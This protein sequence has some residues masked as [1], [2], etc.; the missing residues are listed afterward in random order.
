MS[1]LREFFI[2]FK[3]DA[4]RVQGE[5]EGADKA[6]EKLATDID[7]AGKAMPAGQIAA[8]N[9]AL[10]DAGRQARE[11]D[12]ELHD[13]GRSAD[14]IDDGVRRAN[15][16]LREANKN[17]AALGASFG[18]AIGRL[19]ATAGAYFGGRELITYADEYKNLQSQ[20]KLT[21]KTTEEFANASTGVFRIAQNTRQS[22]E[23]TTSLYASLQR[24]T[25]SL[26]YSQNRLLGVTETINQAITISG[27]S[28]AAA[29]AALVQLGQGFASG[30]LRGEELNSVL[31]Q[32]PR[33]AKAIADGMGVT[34]GQLRQLGQD[35]KITADTVFKALEGQSAAIK[36]EFGQM[37]LTVGSSMIVLRNA[38]VRFV[39]E[40][41]AATGATDKL[42]KGISSLADGMG[43]LFRWL[44]DNRFLIQGFAIGAAAA[45]TLVSAVLWGSLVPGLVTAAAAALV[46]Y[47]PF[48]ALGAA[49]TALAA[50]IALA[51]ED[52]QFFLKGQPSLLGELVKKYEW[53]ART[54]RFI[55]DAIN[56]LGETAETIWSA[57][58]V[59][60]S[61]AADIFQ[62]IA[63]VAGAAFDGV[64][65]VAG[66]IL[67]LLW[68]GMQ[69]LFRIS[70]T[71][72][73]GILAAATEVFQALAPVVMPVLQ[74]IG[75]LVQWVGDIFAAVAKAIWGEWGAMFDR[76]VDRLNFVIG[77]IRS[78]M[79]L[80]E[81]ARVGFEGMVDRATGGRGG[82]AAVAAGQ[83]QMRAAAANPLASQTAASVATRG[84]TS[85]R[86]TTVN[87]GKVEVQTQATDANGIAKSV[88]PALQ[89]EMRRTAQ[90]FDDGIA[91]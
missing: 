72:W 13:A 80:A 87:V 54:V 57:L 39:G 84:A 26:G 41:D 75:Q 83:G 91:R 59:G 33:L 86:Q 6:A 60:G 7:R 61:V 19:I 70:M 4:K 40:F 1:I 24:S 63:R 30:T 34:I 10:N 12:N 77:L 55:G 31:E 53:V 71:V 81:N 52:I 17:A 56:W 15:R 73:R 5:I 79:G 69:L 8:A 42:A 14:K 78:L 66:P 65:Q 74:G 38:A 20:I 58:K 23:G 22:L 82:R 32:A 3:T 47:A 27:T 21:T 35:G 2:L 9:R 11:L 37:A 88:G 16:E 51:W 44:K 90:D 85:T 46:L 89:S 29:N 67:S 68:D 43:T 50:A 18:D 28:A 62:A 45:V 49:A 76:F 36:R 48:I 64:W 25:E